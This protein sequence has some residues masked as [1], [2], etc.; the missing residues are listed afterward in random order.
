MTPLVSY[1]PNLVMGVVRSR[2]RLAG[3]LLAGAGA[4]SFACGSGREKG[5]ET[6]KNGNEH[7]IQA[8]GVDEVREVR[9]EALLPWTSALPAPAP[10]ETCPSSME[11]R[12]AVF[13][14]ATGSGRFDAA[15]T[16]L[17]R[18]RAPPGQQCCFSWC[19]K[20]EVVEPSAVADTCRQPLAFPESYC[21]SELEGGTRGELAS[22]PYARCALAIRPPGAGVFSVPSGA[23]LDP[24]LTARRRQRGDPLCCY[25]WCSI[26]PPGS[27]LAR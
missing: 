24:N 7:G 21:V 18:R 3:L 16:E 10:Y 17:A 14:P 6:A 9:C 15:Q 27:G 4:L 13:P 5:S 8:C 26:A 2:R 20:L 22:E 11:V 25:G 19:G 12:D 1:G 23:L